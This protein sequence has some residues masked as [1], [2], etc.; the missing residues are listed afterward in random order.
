MRFGELVDADGLIVAVE[1]ELRAGQRLCFY[2]AGRVTDHEWR[3]SG[4]VLKARIIEAG[5]AEGFVEFDLLR[6]GE[7]YKA[8]WADARRTVVRV[9]SAVGPLARTLVRG[10]EVRRRVQRRRAG[11]EPPGTAS[12]SE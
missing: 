1:L 2:Q 10:A 5:I 3:G 9:Q 7:S 6:G 12:P 4:S 8:E 11:I